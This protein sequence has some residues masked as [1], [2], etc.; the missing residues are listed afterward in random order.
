MPPVA[1]KEPSSNQAIT[2]FFF[3]AA[4][5]NKVANID[6]NPP[7]IIDTLISKNASLNN[8]ERADTES[9]LSEID[10]R[11]TSEDFVKRHTPRKPIARIEKIDL[12][13]P[14][15]IYDTAIWDDSETEDLGTLAVKK[16][17]AVTNLNT[18]KQ[19]KTLKHADTPTMSS[20]RLLR[21]CQKSGSSLTPLPSSQFS[22]PLSYQV[23]TAEVQVSRRSSSGLE[24]LDS[25]QV[26]SRSSTIRPNARVKASKKVEEDVKMEVDSSTEEDYDEISMLIL[27]KKE[28][29]AKQR[30]VVQDVVSGHEHSTALGALDG[31]VPFSTA[32][33]RS[34]MR[35][36]RMSPEH[37]RKVMFEDERK[38]CINPP[39]KRYKHSLKK[40]AKQAQED[41]YVE[42]RLKELE[43][44][45][46]VADEERRLTIANASNGDLNVDASPGDYMHVVNGNAPMN[47]TAEPQHDPDW[48]VK[49]AMKKL[50]EPE[51]EMRYRFFDTILEIDPTRR[52]FPKLERT[53]E[54][55]M[56]IFASMSVLVLRYI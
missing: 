24:E 41:K 8:K 30:D 43:E 37:K 2:R 42:E 47:D 12:K 4:S 19:A 33:V 22:Q 29:L 34:M 5:G 45:E 36:E 31:E 54:K 18:P 39:L 6:K 16:S 13:R 46:R 25:K 40:L 11:E 55:W 15:E 28:E 53:W 32:H 9:D 44:R 23:G 56:G 7:Q 21:S 35:R 48:R 50:N 14:E 52:P 3:R 26:T 51:K 49:Q 20:R 27:Q 1:L 17:D 10:A 38:K